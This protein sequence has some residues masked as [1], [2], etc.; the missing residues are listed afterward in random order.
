MV[1]DSVKPSLVAV[2]LLPIGE[3]AEQLFGEK[4]ASAVAHEFESAPVGDVQLRL[5]GDDEPV[6][7]VRGRRRKG[8][9]V[10]PGEPDL[11]TGRE[12]TTLDLRRNTP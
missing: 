9:A 7:A 10:A 12:V 5:F 4:G 6:P 2:R 11:E 1:W 3:R 8:K